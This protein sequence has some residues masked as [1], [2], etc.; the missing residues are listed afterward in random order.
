MRI[1]VMAGGAVEDISARGWQRR[2]MMWRSLR[3]AP[4]A[5]RQDGLKI[6]SA[7]GDLYLKDVNVTDDPK[8]V[9]A[10]RG[11]RKHRWRTTSRLAG[12]LSWTGLRGMWSR[13]AGSM[14]CRPWPRRQSMR[15][16]NLTGRG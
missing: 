9:G 7:L 10:G 13:L 11:V 4:I 1:A 14:A 2:G 8:Q 3:A 15:S 12:P 16:S 5:I 6:E